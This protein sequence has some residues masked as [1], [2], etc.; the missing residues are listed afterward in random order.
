M[1]NILTEFDMPKYK[2][3]K[4]ICLLFVIIL[5]GSAFAFSQEETV[6]VSASGF[7]G[8]RAKVLDQAAYHAVIRVVEKNLPRKKPMAPIKTK[9]GN[10][11]RKTGLFLP[12]T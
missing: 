5:W 6:I 10:S 4:S 2:S 8:T 3:V 1:A 9:S 7:G 12:A 11:S